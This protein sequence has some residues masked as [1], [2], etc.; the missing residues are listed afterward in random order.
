MNG[1]SKVFK[2]IT[3]IFIVG[4]LLACPDGRDPEVKGGSGVNIDGDWKTT[5]EYSPEED[6]WGISSFNFSEDNFTL[7]QYEYFN[8]SC[9]Q[10]K[11]S[12]TISGKITHHGT[13]SIR[14]PSGKTAY[15]KDFK[16]D[17]DVKWKSLVSL[18]DN[19]NTL[20]LA[21][22]IDGADRPDDINENTAAKLSKGTVPPPP[23]H[24]DIDG[25]WRTDCIYNESK[26]LGYVLIFKVS[27][28][29]FSYRANTYEDNSCTQS[30][31]TGSKSGEIIYG[32]KLTT[33]SGL[34]AHEI[35]LRFEDGDIWKILVARQ[36]NTL[37]LKS[38]TKDTDRPEDIAGGI[39]FSKQ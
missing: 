13:E 10:F 6:I 36:G 22:G 25:A 37:R 23:K 1:V 16:F 8:S 11:D 26:E 20:Y 5:C 3:V 17:N 29:K 24:V 21:P 15:E 27:G 28:N 32:K 14:T 4:L 7:T 2:L 19:D 34:T 38:D 31:S 35:D 9:S 30:K 18:E 12:G 33:P 39:P